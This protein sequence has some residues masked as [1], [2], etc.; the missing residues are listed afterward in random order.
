[1]DAAHLG[2]ETLDEAVIAQFGELQMR[3][4]TRGAAARGWCSSG[5]G[6]IGVVVIRP[7]AVGNHG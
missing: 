4:L 1:M 5:G 2:S 3:A 7:A 6:T